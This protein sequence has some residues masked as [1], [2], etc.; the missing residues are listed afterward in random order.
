[1]NS[2]VLVGRLVRDTEVRYTQSGKAVATFT[3]AVDRRFKQEGQPQADF[4]PC[5]AWGKT[6]EFAGKYLAKGNRC[7]VEGRIQ[8]RSYE[9][10]DGSK[11]HVTEIVIDQLE[12][13]ENKKK[14]GG[15]FDFGEPITD[16]MR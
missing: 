14:D 15:G 8:I 13:L 1:M 12:F 5:V 6:A 3:L 9:A 11:R 4:I 16:E 10:Q 2:V 7:G